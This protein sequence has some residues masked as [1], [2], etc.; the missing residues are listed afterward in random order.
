[1]VRWIE[2]DRQTTAQRFDSHPVAAL[3][4]SVERVS[5]RL[6]GFPASFTPD[7]RSK[8]LRFAVTGSRE[9]FHL[10][11]IAPAIADGGHIGQ[12]FPAGFGSTS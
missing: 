11:V 1:V 2:I 8:S 7:S 4:R 6:E 5:M 12:Q 9:G 3:P 10:Q